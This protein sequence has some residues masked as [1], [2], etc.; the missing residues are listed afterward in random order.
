MKSKMNHTLCSYNYVFATTPSPLAFLLP[1][2]IAALQNFK[3]AFVGANTSTQ[4]LATIEKYFV[5]NAILKAVFDFY[6]FNNP[7]YKHVEITTP[8]YAQRRLLI[9]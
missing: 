1:T 3:V 4:F 5:Q 9:S 8:L 6:K 7:Y 2:N